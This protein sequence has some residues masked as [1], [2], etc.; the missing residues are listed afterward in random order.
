M[1]GE[2]EHR[3]SSVLLSELVVSAEHHPAG[4]RVGYAEELVGS[5]VSFFG[6]GDRMGVRRHGAL[7]RRG[8]G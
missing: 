4:A 6:R 2:E 5:C 1:T 3:R 8:K 7:A